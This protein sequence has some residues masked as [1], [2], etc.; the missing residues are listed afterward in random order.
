[1]SIA[2]AG[3]TP[4]AAFLYMDD[5]IVIGCSANHHIQNLRRTFES[6][7]KYNLKLNPEKCKFF[8]KEVT[9]LGH[10]ITEKGILPVDTKYEVIKRYP[11]PAS[12][13]T[14]KRFIAFCNYYRR[15]IP[16]F[17]EIAR[18]LNKLTRKKVKFVL[19]QECQRPFEKLKKGLIQPR[20]LRYPDF[21]KQF[22]LSTDASKESCGAVLAQTFGEDELPIAH[23]SRAFTKSETNKPVIEKELSAIHWAI[24]HFRPYLYGTKFLVKTDHRALIYQ[25]SLKNPSSKLTI[26]RLDLEEYEIQYIKEKDNVVADALSRISFQGIKNIQNEAARI[27]PITRS[28]TREAE[29]SPG[30]T[31]KRIH[32]VHEPRIYETLDNAAII[33]ISHTE[34]R[35]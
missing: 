23:A 22:I 11:V 14:V 20:L 9:Y 26:I 3:L 19:T 18:P 32:T 21:V 10:R 6:C 4:E 17:A 16:N 2:F 28:A 7:K 33:K 24:N 30:T 5:L 15:F 1:M 34:I 35:N 31:Q 12:A 27:L 29:R 13:E 8:N 25:Y